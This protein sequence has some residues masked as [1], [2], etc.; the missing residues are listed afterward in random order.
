MDRILILISADSFADA[1]S[2]LRSAHDQAASGQR[3]SYGLTLREQ[4]DESA[5]AEML[6]LGTVQFIAP[7]DDPWKTMPALWQGEGY[8]L[9]AHPTMT[10]TRHWDMT[11]LHALRSC[12]G[13]KN[14]ALTGILP[15]PEDPVEAVFPVA[16]AG[17]NPAGQLVLRKGT[18]LRYARTPQV[19]AFINPNFCF[20][21]A[22]F[23]RDMAEEEPPLFLGAFR[24]R[25]TLMTLH[26]PCI[27][28]ICDLPVPP[29]ALPSG[30]GRATGLGRFDVRFST[31]L[32]EKRLSAMARSGIYTP[33]LLFPLR[34]PLMVRL[35]EALRR[36]KCKTDDPPLCVTAQLDLPGEPLLPQ[37]ALAN[38]SRLCT[39]KELSLLVFANSPVARRLMTVHPNV[40]DYKVRYALPLQA[41]LRPEESLNFFRLSKLFLL[42]TARE[43]FLSH[44]YYAWID[45]GY[46]KYPVYERASVDWQEL[47]R[48]KA[49][50]GQVSGM[51]DPSMFIVPA[52]K[53]KPL[54]Q[55]MLALCAN[56]LAQGR[57]F[58]REEAAWTALLRD[59][60]ELVEA[61]DIPGPGRLLEQTMTTRKE[62]FHVL[63]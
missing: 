31:N 57:P 43:K 3:L 7:A 55:A 13:N 48:D 35:Q 38:F 54:C 42:S 36:M 44:G 52:G 46:L 32:P 34:A 2:A 16:A 4:P 1:S 15:A 5:Q 10:F 37:E 47:C 28:T 56:A 18:P 41:P 62:E 50:I 29:V 9:M 58:P 51:P 30:E 23:F 63:A 39:M 22:S 11:L 61:V 6:S 59:H 19:S 45:F 26:K 8:I 40:L 25:W 33:D 60:P 14:R 53:I 21:P 49:V 12:P 24:R 17:F 27:H 20:G